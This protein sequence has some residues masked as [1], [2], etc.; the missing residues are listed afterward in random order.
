MGNDGGNSPTY[1]GVFS[2]YYKRELASDV[3]PAIFTIPL[4]FFIYNDYYLQFMIMFDSL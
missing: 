2:S 4:V 1:I 3:K